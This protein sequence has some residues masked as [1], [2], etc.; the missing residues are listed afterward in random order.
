VKAIPNPEYS[1]DFPGRLL[2][3]DPDCFK[4]VAVGPSPFRPKC[5]ECEGK[6]Q[7]DSGGQTPNGGWFFVRCPVC[8]GR[9]FLSPEEDAAIRNPNTPK[10]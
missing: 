5:L 9:G 2:I 10:P 3:D 4:R 8:F 7:V 6:G 1:D